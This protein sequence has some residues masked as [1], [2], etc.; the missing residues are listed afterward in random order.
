[1]TASSHAGTDTPTEHDPAAGEEG[2]KVADPADAYGHGPEPA[3]ERKMPKDVL[4]PERVIDV[5]YS[6]GEG[7]TISADDLDDLD[8]DDPEASIAQIESVYVKWT[9]LQYKQATWDAPL[10]SDSP[11]YPAFVIAYGR[12]LRSRH[13]RVPKITAAQA[14]VLDKPKNLATF[15]M[16]D[17]QPEYITGGEL[18][19]FQIE[20]AGW[21]LR[22]W[23]TKNNCLLADEMGLGKT[24]QVIAFLSMLFKEERAQVRRSP[25]TQC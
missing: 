25:T 24:V 22:N 3:A 13:V 4:T 12:W 19:D 2:G 7:G 11:F 10:S 1:M 18:K 6:D 20:G 14:V 8:V 15:K 9:S 23:W 16:P 5:R 17:R 21:L